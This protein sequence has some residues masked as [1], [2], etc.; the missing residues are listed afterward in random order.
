MCQVDRSLIRGRGALIEGCYIPR[1]VEV[2]GLV[3]TEISF[4]TSAV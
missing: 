3:H 2:V 4:S 1:A